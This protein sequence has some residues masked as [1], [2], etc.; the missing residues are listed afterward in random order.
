M[1]IFI[2]YGH[3]DHTQ[4]VDL[5]FD[6][7]VREGHEPWK[8]DRYE[9]NSGIPA[10]QDFTELIYQA[11]DASD[12]VVAFV[13]RQTQDKLYCRDERQRAYNKKDS[14]FIQIRMDYADITLGN[15]RS[16][17]DMS[18]VIESNGQINHRLFEE[19][20]KSLFAA[21]R[22]PHSFSEG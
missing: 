17:I 3:E 2:S 11:I 12:F 22:D 13:T 20:L 10:G 5:L 4:V 9:G 19:K 14:H 15:A 16:Y 18:D 8:D 6:A 7:L 1:K 21:F